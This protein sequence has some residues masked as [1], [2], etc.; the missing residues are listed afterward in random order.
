MLNSYRLRLHNLQTG[1][2]T[3]T[4]LDEGEGGNGHIKRPI[5]YHRWPTTVTQAPSPTALNSLL[6]PSL[7]LLLPH[8]IVKAVHMERRLDDMW[9][10]RNEVERKE[11]GSERSLM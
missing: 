5:L 2:Q 3:P 10:R 4:Q 6:D 7:G 8:M 1:R 9:K 11:R